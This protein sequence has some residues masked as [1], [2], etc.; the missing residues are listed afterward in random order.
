MVTLS[1]T[2]NNGRSQVNFNVL[3]TGDYPFINIAKTSQSFVYAGGGAHQFEHVDPSTLDTNGYPTTL[4]AGG[5]ITQSLGPSDAAIL[6]SSWTMDWDGNGTVSPPA[7]VVTGSAT[8]SGGSGSLTFTPTSSTFSWGI[9][10]TSASPNHIR[11]IRIYKT[12]EAANLAAGEVFTSTFKNGLS[13]A[14]FGVLRFLNWQSANT[15]NMTTW[16]TRKPSTFFSYSATEFRASLYCGATGG[17]VNT[18]TITGN[19]TGVSASGGP[20]DKTMLHLRF[21]V[22]AS[23]ASTLSLNGTT[24]KT[25]RDSYGGTSF[26]PTGLDGTKYVYATLIFDAVLDSWICYGANSDGSIGIDS[27]VPPELCIQICAEVGAH[28]WYTQP[29]MASGPPTDFMTQLA[30]HIRDTY[31]GTGWPCQWMIPRFEGPNEFFNQGFHFYQTSMAAQKSAV[32]WSGG[33]YHDYYG[34]LMSMIGQDVAA[35]YST[36]QANVKTQTKYQMILGMQ[37]FGGLNGSDEKFNASK[38][39]SLGPTVGSYTRSA[40]KDWATHACIATYYNSAEDQTGPEINKA[41]DYYRRSDLAI[42]DEYITQ[43]FNSNR[44]DSLGSCLTIFSSWKTYIK[45]FGINK[46]CA[47]EGGHSPDYFNPYANLSSISKAA[48][49][50]VVTTPTVGTITTDATALVGMY[51]KISN[52]GGMTEINN[53]VYQITAATGDTYTL[54]VNSSGFTTYTSGGSIDFYADSGGTIQLGTVLNT[55][56]ETTKYRTLLSSLNTAVYQGFVGV[57][58]ATFTAEFPSHYLFTGNA[59]TNARSAWDLQNDIF[60]SPKSAQYVSVKNFNSVKRASPPRMRLHV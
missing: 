51:A 22:N 58:D 55:F 35:V 34:M 7:S 45:T 4:P 46:M 3:G 53:N 32:L 40:A 49:A 9:S 19:G 47:Y 12:S 30:T 43:A 50:V 33:N 20:S 48:Q 21:H 27:G 54:N 60:E 59:A 5:V 17:S 2:F 37:T 13:D 38:Y 39:I 36:V 28:P 11:N 6:A 56:K 41:V 57:S 42:S 16:A 26:S 14:G 31:N 25:I 24:A 23:G 10:S 52:A 8:S 18:Y 29:I 44:Y 1:P 15:T